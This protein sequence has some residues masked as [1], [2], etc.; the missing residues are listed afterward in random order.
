[1]SE[2]PKRGQLQT[3]AFRSWDFELAALILLRDTDYGVVRGALVPAEVVREQS[4]FAAHTNAHSVHMNSRLM[5]HARAVDI[6]AQLHA[7]AGG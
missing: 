1:M 2:P 6:T 5:D 7:A 3:S 4:R